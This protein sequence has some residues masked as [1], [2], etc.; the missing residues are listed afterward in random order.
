MGAL[1][2]ES[3]PFRFAGLADDALALPLACSHWPAGRRHW[4]APEFIFFSLFF[5]LSY[6]RLKNRLPWY[7]G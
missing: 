5:S 7:P 2:G 1:W 6:N 3:V 4:T